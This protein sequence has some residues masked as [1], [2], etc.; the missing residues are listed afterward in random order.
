MTPTPVRA[1]ALAR[2]AGTLSL[3]IAATSFSA[4][5]YPAFAGDVR[6]VTRAPG[7]PPHDH[8]GHRLALVDLGA[9]VRAQIA[10][11]DHAG[12][13]LVIA[14]AAAVAVAGLRVAALVVLAALAAL[15]VFPWA[16]RDRRE[17]PQHP[18]RSSART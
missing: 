9:G 15:A 14:G 5:P 7:A 13:P 8:P 12:L 1:C 6:R 11:L 2:F 10:A 4:I 18:I 16:A 3:C 17:R